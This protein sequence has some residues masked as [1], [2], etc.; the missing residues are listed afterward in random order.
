MVVTL[1]DS[2]YTL[3]TTTPL[4]LDLNGDGIH[5][6]PLNRGVLFDTN[7]TGQVKPTGWTE[8]HTGL[9]ALD[10][11]GDGK[12]NDGAELF[13]SETSTPNGKAIAGADGLQH[14]MADVWFTS[15]LLDVLV[16]Q[17]MQKMDLAADAAANVT[18]VH[19][20]D[21]L[22]TDQKLMVVKA[23]TNDMVNL[24]TMGW[25]NSGTTTTVDNNTYAL[26]NNG[27]AHLLI[28]Q[29]ALVH[30]VL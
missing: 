19:L 15:T 22:A 7:S 27:A 4:V 25:S 3:G 5:T 23:G 14:A 29:N 26:W 2:N 9:L 17:A 16:Q 24:D 18:N 6:S 21:V 8:N 28:H 1:Q 20:A 30:Q 10:L 12:I 11:N 13:G